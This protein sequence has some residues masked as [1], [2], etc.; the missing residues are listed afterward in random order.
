MTK[1]SA[2]LVTV[3]L[4]CIAALVLTG[5]VIPGKIPALIVAGAGATLLVW[6]IAAMRLPNLRIQPEVAQ[7]ATL[8]TQGPYRVIRHPMYAG[9]ML[10]AAG[11]VWND[12]TV[13]RM[14]AA[15]ILLLDYIVKL[16]YEETLLR[17]RFPEYAEY[18]QR[19]K[20]LLPFIY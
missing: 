2:V 12:F 20:R 7:N 16:A 9:G 10:I 3:Q 11:W 5:P 17:E 18:M 19:T 13:M 15:L 6:A 14:L 4:T 8:V 1:K